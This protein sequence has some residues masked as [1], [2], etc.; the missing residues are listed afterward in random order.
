MH[1]SKTLYLSIDVIYQD[2]VC[3]NCQNYTN[4]TRPNK[5]LWWSNKSGLNRQT[6]VTCCA[7]LM[8][9]DYRSEHGSDREIS[10]LIP[11]AIKLKLRAGTLTVKDIESIPRCGGAMSSF[12]WPNIARSFDKIRGQIILELFPIMRSLL[13]ADS[14][15]RYVEFLEFQGIAAR[16]EFTPLLVDIPW[17]HLEFMIYLKIWCDVSSRYALF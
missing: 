7:C 11:T 8:Q 5:N 4:R 10:A 14:W 1:K 2:W 3:W 13:Y 6:L 9:P 15:Y 16:A 17:G 12:S